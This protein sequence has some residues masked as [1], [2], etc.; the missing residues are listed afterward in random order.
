MKGIAVAESSRA[1]K[2]PKVLHHIEVHP[3]LGGGVRVEHHHTSYEHPVETHEFAKH[4]GDKF[5]DHMSEHTGMHENL[6]EQGES[7][8]EP[9]DKG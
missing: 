7:E 5:H 1:K 2:T 9:Y 6:E 3:Q 8:P 4:E